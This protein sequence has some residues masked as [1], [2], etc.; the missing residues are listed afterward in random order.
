MIKTFYQDDI[1][2]RLAALFT[3]GLNNDY[4]YKS[5]EEHIVS[6]SF[7]NCLENNDYEIESKIET[8]VETAFNIS[9]NGSQADISF[10]GLFFAESYLRLF[11]YFNRSFE[12]LFLYW[13]LEVFDEKYGI[14]HEMD[15]SNLRRDFQKRVAEV[16][17][18]KKLCQARQIKI[19]DISKLT[20]I[21]IHTIDR[22]ARDDKY[23]YSSSHDNIF[24]LSKLFDVKENIFIANLAV[25]LDQSIYLSDKSNKDYRNFLG[26]YFANYYDNRINEFDFTYSKSNNFFIS[27]SG[28]KLVVVADNLDNLPLPK[29]NEVADKNTYLVLIPSGFFGDYSYFEYLNNANA[30]EVFILTQEYIYMVK[31]GIKKEITDTINRSLIIRAKEAS[32][33]N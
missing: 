18:L 30:L 14:Y 20:G 32:S 22:Y 4:S 33:S 25:F 27:K 5:I 6:S 21:N 10:K 15:F 31:K 17:L 11:L 26:L 12:Y 16:T 19:V 13:P 28:V 2:N 3:Y 7:V 9:L 24:K 1:I 23:L 29:I 8:I